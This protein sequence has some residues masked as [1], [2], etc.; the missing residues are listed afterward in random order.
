MR[1]RAE[2]TQGPMELL[3]GTWSKQGGQGGLLE[4]VAWRGQRPTGQLARARFGHPRMINSNVH[5]C[6]VPGL[7][8][9]HQGRLRDNCLHEP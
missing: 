7:W 1:N 4:E 8:D 6:F 3:H 9:L 2:E 5:R